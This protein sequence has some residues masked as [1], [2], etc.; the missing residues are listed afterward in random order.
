M[1]NRRSVI[2]KGHPTVNEQGNATEVI[3]P[4][5]LVKGV[6]SIAKQTSTTKVP[7]AFALERDE[8]GKGV[9]DLY[10]TDAAGAAAYAIGDTVKVGV[11]YSGCEVLAYIPSGQ[12]IVEDDLLES[13]GTGLLQ[14][15]S[16]NP[17][18]RAKQTLGAITV[19]TPCIVELL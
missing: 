16:T 10:E 1:A 4:G 2:I 11:F 9:D 3:K 6:S 19:E 12:N 15:G 13:A 8:L 18:A 7:K 5:Y 14:E 17:I